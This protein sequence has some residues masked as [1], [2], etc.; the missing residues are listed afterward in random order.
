M[1]IKEQ[2]TRLTLHEHV[3]DAADDDDDEVSNQNP[4]H[5]I[6]YNPRNLIHLLLF[7]SL[8]LYGYCIL[9]FNSVFLNDVTRD[10]VI[11]KH[12]QLYI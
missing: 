9:N 5:C 11:N 3:D 1:R 10:L 4:N 7:T 6:Y 8:K 2:E 12:C